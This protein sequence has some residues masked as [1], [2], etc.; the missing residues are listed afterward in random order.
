L[1]ELVGRSLESG[2]LQMEMSNKLDGV[3]GKLNKESELVIVDVLEQVK[4]VKSTNAKQLSLINKS[5]DEKVLQTKE[6]LKKINSEE[7]LRRNQAVKADKDNTKE[8][9]AEIAQVEEKISSGKEEGKVGVAKVEE[10][11]TSLLEEKLKEYQPKGDTPARK[12][13]NFP[14]SL[15]QPVKKEQ[16]VEEVRR[17]R[18]ER[19]E[20]ERLLR[21]EEE[22]AIIQAEKEEEEEQTEVVKVEEHNESADSG[23][24]SAA[25]ARPSFGVDSVADNKENMTKMEEYV[26][27][28]KRGDLGGRRR[29]FGSSK[30]INAI[31]K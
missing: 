8:M 22:V 24:V 5:R 3:A 6:N 10:L 29:Q 1:R 17:R 28:S 12:Q 20:K 11:A 2:K 16:L 7:A 13:S 25:S 31:A 9:V 21:E 30:N 23:V 27:P 26:T 19:K 4:E 15:I 14:R 18:E